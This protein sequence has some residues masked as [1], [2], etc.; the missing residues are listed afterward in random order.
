MKLSQLI[1]KKY[2]A[3]AIFFSLLTGL[4]TMVIP[5][6]V[7]EVTDAVQTANQMKLLV[8]ILYGVVGFSVLQLALYLWNDYTA[9]VIKHFNIELKKAI[10]EKGFLIEG[11]KNEVQTMI[12]N[13]V[14]MLAQNYVYAWIHMVYCIW[15][16]FVSIIYVLSISWQVALIFIVFSGVPILLPKVFEKRLSQATMIWDEENQRFVKELDEDLHTS[17]VIRHYQR[18]TYFLKRYVTSLQAREKAEYNKSHLTYFVGLM[19]SVIAGT[20][21]LIPFGLGG[22]LAIQGYLTLGG[23]LAVFMS[24]DRIFG[25]LENAVNYWTISKPVLR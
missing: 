6:V 24:S 8:V 12:Y 7:R 11:E 5:T 22:Y 16:S 20:T 10:F 17:S 3:I 23:L 14:P 2:A 19:I 1:H 4:D 9:K 18:F 13:D 21:A 15:F 25:P